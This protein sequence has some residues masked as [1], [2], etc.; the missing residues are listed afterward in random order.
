M[1]LAATSVFRESGYE[2]EILSTGMGES[3]GSMASEFGSAG[4]AVHHVR[5]AKTPLF[6]LRVY[7]LM[8]RGR[9]DVIH[10]HTE[11]A[12]F[13]LGL[14]AL[15]S[16]PQRVVRTIHSVF[17]FEG[18]LRR[19]RGLQRRVLHRLG[20]IHVACGP[21][22]QR[23]ERARY[24]LPTRLAPSWYD[25]RL[26]FPPSRS[27]RLEA[28]R[29]LAIS[30]GEIVLVTTGTCAPVKNHAALIEALARLPAKRRPL[31][32]HVGTEERGH[33]ERILAGTLGVSVRFL[34][35]VPD[36]RTIYAACDLFA[37]SSLYEGFS[38][39]I[40]EA[41]ANGLPAL[42]TDVGGLADLRPIYPGLSYA[43]PTVDSLAQA[44]TELMA[45]TADQRRAHSGQYAEVTRRTFG[46]EAG[47]ERYIE[48][49][50][51]SK[52]PVSGE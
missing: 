10:L 12:N 48:I 7:R 45:Q 39:A 17:A 15:A 21:T 24:R 46:L 40:L 49:Y 25:T 16:R 8:R 18:G 33:P 50:R 6:F 3:A 27:E 14:V 41:L 47:V 20:V 38:V 36:L 35:P 37:M 19:R 2:G 32:L 30:D 28:R 31:Y 42:V 11:R 26:F 5:F 44:L 43:E 34:G 29:A 23:N 22:V 9:Y 52:A 51:G 13:W 4:V 1:L